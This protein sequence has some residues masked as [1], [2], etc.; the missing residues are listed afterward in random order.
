MTAEDAF[1]VA[2]LA[3]DSKEELKALSDLSD[4]VLPEVNLVIELLVVGR[5]L[6]VAEHDDVVFDNLIHIL[7][8]HDLVVVLVV[9][10]ALKLLYFKVSNRIILPDA[11]DFLE[12]DFDLKL[13]SCIISKFVDLLTV[14]VK[15]ELE[16]LL[17]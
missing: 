9:S 10:L 6:H 13:F 7:S 5:A 14:V 15:A 1:K 8:A 16:D 3:L 11:S 4:V 17:E 12:L 2:P